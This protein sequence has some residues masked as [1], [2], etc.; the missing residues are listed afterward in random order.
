MGST[1]I[2][3]DARR[4]PLADKSVQMCVTSPPYFGLRDDGTASWDGG[5][6]ECDHKSNRGAQG[7]TGQ[8]ADRTFTGGEIYKDACRKCGAARIDKQL[9]LEPTPAEY[10]ASMVIVFREVRRVLRDDGVC[11]LNI[12]DSY[13]GAK[14]SKQWGYIFTRSKFSTCAHA[15]RSR[16]RDSTRLWRH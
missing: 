2:Q 11:W 6:V 3:S 1:L 8:R 10:V 5:D 16:A 12:G 14:R 15:R 9:G 13:C 4:L 7:S